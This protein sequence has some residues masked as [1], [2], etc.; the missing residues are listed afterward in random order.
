[1][2]T[3]SISA[4]GASQSLVIAAPA[5]NKRIVV[6]GFFFV[7]SAAQTF[8]WQ[9]AS[10]D[11]NPAATLATGVPIQFGPFYDGVFDCNAAEALN[12]TTTTAAQLSGMVMYTIR[13]A[14][15]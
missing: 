2:L 1:M 11:L 15:A 8:K 3:A 13:P 6:L 5:A 14:A 7:C 12:I 4:S 9:S 10:N